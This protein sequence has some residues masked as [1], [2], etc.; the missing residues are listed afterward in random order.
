M[1]DTVFFF[2]CFLTLESFSLTV[3]AYD[4]FIAICFP[5]RQSSINTNTAM[6]IIIVTVWSL[7]ISVLLFSAIILTRLSFCNSLIIESYFCDYGPVYRLS[8]NDYSLQWTTASFVSFISMFGPLSLTGISYTCI[9]TAVFRMNNVESRHKALA[10]CTE[11]LIVVAIFY[12]PMLA[13]IINQLFLLT[14]DTDVNSVIMS[15]ATCIPPCLNPIVYSLAT[16]EIKNR[17][18]AMLQK[19]KTSAWGGQD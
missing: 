2:A 1:L 18:Q 16:K 9:L 11:H 17:I 12:G 13:S 15:F 7:C 14:L 5:L 10:T 4:R 6:I 19:V 8:C 3:L